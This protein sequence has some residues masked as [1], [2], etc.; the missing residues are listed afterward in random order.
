M[1]KITSKVSNPGVELSTAPG[2]PTIATPIEL[3]CN[4]NG[5]KIG[6]ENNDDEAT[7]CE[8]NGVPEAYFELSDA[9]QSWGTDGLEKKVR[10]YVN[11]FVTLTF[12]PDKDAA[13]S[14]DNPWVTGVGRVTR[15][16]FFD[17]VIK[18]ATTFVLRIDSEGRTWS[19]EDTDGVVAFT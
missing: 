1:A 19:K 4:A 17:G 7:F 16:D 8:P 11:Q 3:E 15:F 6:F 14:D 18:G 9:V 5:F 10:E 12:K 13:A 2:G